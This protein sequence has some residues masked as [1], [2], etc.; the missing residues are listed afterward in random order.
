[1]AVP[2]AGVGPVELFSMPNCRVP[3]GTPHVSASS[4]SRSP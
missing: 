4:C 1:M 2:V 3:A